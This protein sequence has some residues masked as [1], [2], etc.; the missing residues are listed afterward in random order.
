MDECHTFTPA[1]M[2]D[3][4]LPGTGIT[5]K[6]QW[7]WVA[8]GT[9]YFHCSVYNAAVG[10]MS[11]DNGVAYGIRLP[12]PAASQARQVFSG[13]LNNP[14]GYTAYPTFTSLT[15]WSGTGAASS[16]FSVYLP[17]PSSTKGGLDNLRVFPSK[18]TVT[19]SGTYEANTFDNWSVVNG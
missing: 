17:S 3:S 5:Y 1:L 12:V 14:S 16:Y 9:V 13:I 6:G 19:F 7:R 11:S 2:N 15:G 10:D 8:P 4:N 18:A